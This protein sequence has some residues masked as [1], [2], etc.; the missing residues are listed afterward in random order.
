MA[1]VGQFARIE[2]S[3]TEIKREG[4]RFF[5]IGAKKEEQNI[6][7]HFFAGNYQFTDILKVLTSCLCLGIAAVSSKRVYAICELNQVK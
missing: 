5:F 7:E 2:Q 6:G 4:H 3:L 1:R